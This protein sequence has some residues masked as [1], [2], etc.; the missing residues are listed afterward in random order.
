MRR[1]HRVLGPL[2][3]LPLVLWVVTGLLFHV[4]HRYGEAYEVLAVPLAAQPDWTS[5][6][7]SPAA[8]LRAGLARAPLVLA[9]HPSGRL[10]YFGRSADGPVALDAESGERIAPA[11]PDAARAWVAA[12]IAASSCPERFGT[13]LDSAPTTLRSSRTGGEDPALAVR[14]DGSKTVTV[15]LLTGEMS[16][17]G[18]LNDFIDRTYALHY[19]QWTPWEP[20]NVALV[21]LSIPLVIALAVTGLWLSMRK[22]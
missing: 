1:F 12:A 22:P 6:T 14:T 19:L 5:A 8:V 21:L 13:E 4:K 2:L 15:D 18:A 7:L 9:S 10:A 20:V 16:Q 3:A 17:T 11:T